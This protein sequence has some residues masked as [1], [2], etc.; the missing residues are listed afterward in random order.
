[1]PLTNETYN[2]NN[3]EHRSWGDTLGQTQALI[4]TGKLTKDT[5]HA[6]YA[7]HELRDAGVSWD[8]IYLKKDCPGKGATVHGRSQNRIV[9]KVKDGTLVEDW[10]VLWRH[11]SRLLL[12]S[13]GFFK[14]GKTMRDYIKS[15]K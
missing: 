3:Q 13:D 11:D 12:L 10:A 1:M 6:Y 4:E 8:G 14:R 5:S 15:M 9:V 2:D 7:G